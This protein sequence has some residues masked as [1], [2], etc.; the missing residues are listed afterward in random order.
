[1]SL[2]CDRGRAQGFSIPEVL[3]VIVSMVVIIVA[4]GQL[5]FGARRLTMRQSAQVEARQIARGAADYLAMMVRGANDLMYNATPMRQPLAVVAWVWK[6]APAAA[7][8]ATIPA[9]PGANECVQASWD[10][11]GRAGDPANIADA[12]TDV[13][14]VAH[15]NS[16]G[17][18]PTDT[19]PVVAGAPSAATAK[20]TFND[21][22][23][24]NAANLAMFKTF[25]GESSG[26]SHP[27]VGLD[28]TNPANWGWYQITTYTASHCSG[29]CA[30][31]GAACVEAVF[32]AGLDGGL[33]FPPGGTP[34]AASVRIMGG[35]QYL[36]YRI[37][38]GWLEQK[39]GIFDPSV[40]AGN[41]A[42]ACS[43]TGA[44]DQPPWTPLLPNVEDLQ[45]V[46]VYDNGN[47][48]NNVSTNEIASTGAVPIQGNPGNALDVAHVLAIR[49]T[50]T[51]RSSS[52]VEI[53]NTP[54][55][56]RPAAENHAAA[57]TMDAFQ[58]YQASV[59]ALLRNRAPGL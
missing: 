56:L 50:V 28:S 2:I 57:T 52:S 25:T 58:H 15:G 38:R 4:S 43:T 31:A 1:M 24:D 54:L 17:S 27:L 11:V 39:D 3:V 30:V 36:T 14:V 7:I 44:W 42:N 22:C 5:L 46:W 6:R 18:I 16:G 32:N 10:N 13:L 51:T 19:W 45:V 8:P 21:G 55:F 20:W 35:V 34:A 12:G 47:I 41:G 59:N 49:L 33:V 37:C 9:C 48:R 23:S 53:A 29:G 26:V 40:D